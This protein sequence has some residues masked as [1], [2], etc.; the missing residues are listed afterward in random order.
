MQAPNS[1]ISRLLAEIFWEGK[2]SGYREGGRGRENVLT[3]EVFQALDFLPRTTFL[4]RVIE[5]ASGASE[6]LR[7]LGAGIEEATV[8]LFAGDI[9][10]AENPPAGEMQLY[11]QPDGIIQTSDVYCLVEAKRVGRSS[12]Q[13]EQL[14]RE[15]VAV[16]QEAGDRHPLLLL[17]LPGPPPIAVK[18]HGRMD[19][20]DAV[21]QWTRQ[22]VERSES[23][24]PPIEEVLGRIDATVAFTTWAEI[25][26]Q[27]AEALE[28][29][30]AS[31]QSVADSVTR[32]ADA[33]RGA[34]AWHSGH[35][36]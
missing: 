33:I 12:F 6:T 16:L 30:S 4:G 7:L 18:A 14:A 32:L 24:L 34:I 28:T 9:F 5:S 11:V 36:V 31:D 10:L 8:D 1:A 20:H 21:E 35:T 15:Y 3:A 29:F 25:S 17:I 22:V 2:T 19:I 27:M 13:P 23:E 26:K